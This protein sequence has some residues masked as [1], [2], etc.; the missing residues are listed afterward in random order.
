M[1]WLFK[2]EN[3]R[4]LIT[5]VGLLILFRVVEYL[6]LDDV[7][8]IYCEGNKCSKQPS[9]SLLFDIHIDAILLSVLWPLVFVALNMLDKDVRIGPYFFYSIVVCNYL[10]LAISMGVLSVDY[11]TSPS[12]TPQGDEELAARFT[13]G[14]TTFLTASVTHVISIFLYRKK[15]LLFPNPSKE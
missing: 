11:L 7:L 15:I 12:Q 4:Y 6:I 9:L 5:L 3:A 2:K 14:L 1:E 8:L 13:N 10:V